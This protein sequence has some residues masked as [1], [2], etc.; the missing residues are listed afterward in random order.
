MINVLI[1]LTT[2][3]LN[4]DPV[5]TDTVPAAL[6]PPSLNLYTPTSGGFWSVN[7]LLPPAPLFKV[8]GTVNENVFDVLVPVDND[9]ELTCILPAL[10]YL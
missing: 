5:A 1:P 3:L 9:I 7:W 4:G 8:L 2:Y 10:V 6:N